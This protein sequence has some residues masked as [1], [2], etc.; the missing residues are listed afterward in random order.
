VKN[1]IEL[2]N[3]YAP[4]NK[5]CIE[6][7]TNEITEIHLLKDEHL[8][9]NNKH[10]D[11][12]YFI[13]EGIVR[14]YYLKEGKDV[15]DWFASKN[16]FIG[17]ILNIYGDKPIRQYVQVLENTKLLVIKNNALERLYKK[18]HSFERI[19]RLI[20]TQNLI[21]L[22]ERVIAL[23]FY[24]AKEKY[25]LLLKQNPEIIKRVALTH[26]ASYLGITLE[27]LSRVRSQ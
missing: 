11:S 14:V 7:L 5:D 9:D 12:F 15:T 16:K 19:G 4:L 17:P 26:I 25:E 8:E 2:L 27:T 3:N 24:S 1:F 18:H 22:N 21:Q 10:P 13:V 20:V 6:D 23:Q